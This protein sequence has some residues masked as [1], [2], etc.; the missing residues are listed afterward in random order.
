MAKFTLL[1][2]MRLPVFKMM[3]LLNGDSEK[4]QGFHHVWWNGSND[5]EFNESDNGISQGPG[6]EFIYVADM[7]GNYSNSGLDK[8]GTFIQKV[9]GRQAY[10]TA[11]GSNSDSPPVI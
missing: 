1:K 7:N 3:E 2:D 4:M 6:W 11:P 5:G 10:G 8:N 9:W